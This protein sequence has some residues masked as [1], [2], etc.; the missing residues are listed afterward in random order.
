MDRTI[1]QERIDT[2]IQHDEIMRS[3]VTLTFI[4]I[5]TIGCGNYAEAQ[6]RGALISDKTQIDELVDVT[7]S[8]A[9]EPNSIT[10]L[11]EMLQYNNGR[12]MPFVELSRYLW[13][14]ETGLFEIR[15]VD[16]LR[17]AV[18]REKII[19]MLDEPLWR[20]RRACESGNQN[21]CQEIS[22][23]YRNT[24]EVFSEIKYLLGYQMFHVEA[25]AELIDQKS[26][27]GK[28]MVISAADHVGFNCYGAID[29]CHGHSQWEYGGWIYE[30]IAGTGKRIILTVGTWE[31]DAVDVVVS[32]ID[33]YFDIFRSRPDIFS[34]IG[35]FTWGDSGGVIGAREIP[36]IRE[37]LIN[38]FK[39]N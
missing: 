26:Q 6:W 21:S 3:L 25:Y 28:V 10:E 24:Q 35:A 34:G 31:F 32:Q 13:N 33:Q 22:H 30:A 5:I 7:N 11:T 16:E 4:I 8:F 15:G 23:G 29:N 19:I 37:A 39:E 17:D 1:K 20:I 2:R 12:L 36:E 18:G 27:F 9:F 14:D 38:Q